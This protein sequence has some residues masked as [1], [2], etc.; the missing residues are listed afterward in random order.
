MKKMLSILLAV[1]L[2]VALMPFGVVSAAEADA[3]DVVSGEVE[4]AGATIDVGEASGVRGDTVNVTVSLVN[5]PG[6]ISAKLSLSYDANVLELTG[7][8][9]GEAFASQ[10][11]FSQT[12]DKN[13]Y[14]CNW[15]DA[16]NPDVTES[17][18]VT[19]SFKIKDTAVVGKTEITVTYDPEDV[20]DSNYDN[21]DFAVDAGYVT[22]N[23]KTKT[24]GYVAPTCTE[25]G[26]TGDQ[27]C[28][29]CGETVEK[30][31]DIDSLG[32]DEIPHKAQAP[33]CTNIGWHEYVT[34]SRC[35]Y[36]TYVEIKAN[37]HTKGEF[38]VENV[39]EPS[40][41]D[42]G[43]YDSVCYCVDCKTELSRTTTET[44]RGHKL[45]V[46][47]KCSDCGITVEAPTFFV[48][49]GK[50]MLGKEVKVNVV[51]KNNPGIISMKLGIDYDESVFELIGHEG[52]AFTDVHYGPDENHPFIINW[53]DSI[54]PDNTT[55]GIIATL[56]FKVK[57]DAQ[58]GESVITVEYNPSDVF[59][60]EFK[61]IYIEKNYGYAKVIKSIP[62]DANGDTKVN[63]KDLALLMQHL[64]GWDVQIDLDA[65]DVNADGKV[66]NKDS[67]LLM[68]Y[69]NQWDVELK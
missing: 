61:N 4:F 8:T 52:G 9:P 1:V 17:D 55:D 20:F 42:M 46:N 66:N 64:S 11:K 65:V 30:G 60:S 19:L 13:P 2:V 40:C 7:K 59:D 49:S 10:M 25:I 38:T 6:I 35:D 31:T 41:E 57:D 51:I 14:I 5:N 33:D 53:V 18:F 69:L 39:V 43:S 56:T 37:G 58:I 28:E 54:H 29:L 36:S 45:D 12:L 68:Q 67:A 48:T 62:G 21:V 23:H 32:H 22:V 3:L 16:I 47:G 63:N 50:A 26:Y 44:A 34:C 24:V 27:V 15:V